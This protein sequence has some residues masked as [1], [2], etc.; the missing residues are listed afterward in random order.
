[1]STGNQF[2]TTI[3]VLTTAPRRIN[4]FILRQ[5]PSSIAI[6]YYVI[7]SYESLVEVLGL[8]VI[9]VFRTLALVIRIIRITTVIIR[10]VLIFVLN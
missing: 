8:R 3:D 4:K 1:M 7:T 2:T 10:R 5:Y 6:L 9:R